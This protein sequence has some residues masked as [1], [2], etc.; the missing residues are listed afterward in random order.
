VYLCRELRAIRRAR[1]KSNDAKESCLSCRGVPS[2]ETLSR[3][4][5]KHLENNGRSRNSAPRDF[6]SIRASANGTESMRR[7]FDRQRQNRATSARRNEAG[8]RGRTR[9]RDDENFERI[10]PSALSAPS[11]RPVRYIRGHLNSLSPISVGRTAV[12]RRAFVR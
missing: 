6:R 4:N 10:D 7:S 12:K 2:F 11:P 9:R 1:I 5:G 8:G 3:V